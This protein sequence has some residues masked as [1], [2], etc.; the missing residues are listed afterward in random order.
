[1]AGAAILALAALWAIQLWLNLF[2]SRSS[3]FGKYAKAVRFAGGVLIAAFLAYRSYYL[4]TDWQANPLTK[5]LLPP[6]R[7]PAYFLGYIFWRVWGPWI[8]AFLAALLAKW[9][10]EFLNRRGGGRF[11]REEEPE[12]FAAAVF[13]CGWPGFI[14]Y[15]L[16]LAAAAAVL[17]AVY[18]FLG[19]GRAPLYFLWFPAA[20]FAILI[21]YGLLSPILVAHFNL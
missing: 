13:F 1:M 17:T 18:N 20:L 9:S 7:S 16:V 21:T 15:A 5:Y 8:L 2:D 10:A 4:Y 3:R 19:K 14:F 12:M 6:Y 11:F